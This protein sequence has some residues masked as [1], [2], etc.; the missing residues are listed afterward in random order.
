MDSNTIEGLIYFNPS[1]LL[2]IK[3]EKILDSINEYLPYSTGIEIECDYSS[4]FKQQ[5]FLNIQDIVDVNCDSHEQRFRIPNH[6]KGLICLYNICEQLKKDCLLNPLSGIHLHIDMT[7]TF[8]LLTKEIVNDNKEWILKELDFW[9]E[10]IKET[11]QSRD[12]IIDIRCWVN[13]SSDTKTAEFRIFAQS[14]N[15]DFIIARIIHCNKIIKRL[16]EYLISSQVERRL[17]KLQYEL[18]QLEV[19]NI[20]KEISQEQINKVTKTRII[21]I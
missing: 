2:S 3:N 4:S 18:N 19:I 8:H 1:T 21:K 14:F 11:G 9:S 20:K 7:D 6:L 10:D 17:R 13:F 5:N 12:C 16:K 15:Y